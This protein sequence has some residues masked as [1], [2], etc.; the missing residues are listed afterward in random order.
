M[1]R[2]EVELMMK[3]GGIIYVWKNKIIRE[4][5][6]RGEIRRKNILK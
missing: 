1:N 2:E 3:E 4:D 5:E 6:G